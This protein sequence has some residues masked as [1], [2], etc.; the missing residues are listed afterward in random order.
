MVRQIL[1]KYLSILTVVF[2]VYFLTAKQ[3]IV[4]YLLDQVIY[5]VW[6]WLSVLFVYS[7]Y[8]PRTIFT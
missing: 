8:N 4:L 3:T 7:V 5:T 2:D 1:A 6:N